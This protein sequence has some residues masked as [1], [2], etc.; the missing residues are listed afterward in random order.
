MTRN[1]TA[2]EP[3]RLAMAYTRSI[4]KNKLEEQLGGALGEFYKAECA[5]ANGL[6][7]WVDHWANEANRLLSYLATQ[8]YFHPI[9]GFKDRRKALAEAIAEL[10]DVDSSYRTYAMNMV[11]KDY[12]IKK[13]KH[14]VPAEASDRFYALVEEHIRSAEQIPPLE[15][16]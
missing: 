1:A 12:A 6:T 5:K 13:L 14:A 3:R 8:V 7:K 16:E 2:G 9:R 10:R 15:D 11:V 4:F